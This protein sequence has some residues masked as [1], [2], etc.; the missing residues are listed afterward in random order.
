MAT[1]GV[2]GATGFIAGTVVPRLAS[3]GHQLVLVDNGTG[4]MRV[5]HREWPARAEDFASDGAL[6]ALAD[7]DVVLHLAAVSGVM[8]CARD[9]DGSARVNVEGTRRLARACAD[10]GV[11]IAF[12][13]SLAVVGTPDQLPVTE[14]TT[15]R[16]THAYARQK[17][18]GEA[19]VR[20]E[21]GRRGVA[22]AVLRMSNVYG[23]YVVEGRRVTKGNVLQLFVQQALR[24]GRLTVNAPGTQ[25]RDFV[26]ID[27]VAAH[28][29]AAVEYLRSREQGSSTTFNAASGES[30][31]VREIAELIAGEWRRRYPDRPPL[32]VEV[33]PNPREGIELVDPSFS[34]SRERTEAELGLA[35]RH[36]LAEEIPVELDHA[37]AESR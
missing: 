6:R 33:V 21:L 20:T 15:A 26:H 29:E 32:R 28:W 14:A 8:A 23:G 5:A 13:S 12:A 22:N 9:P 37:A 2:T 7:C 25:R 4:P 19:I 16:P 35:C 10:A 24:D 18:E 17:A 1:V 34:V 36:R 27:D 30:R 31:S 3:A 11:P